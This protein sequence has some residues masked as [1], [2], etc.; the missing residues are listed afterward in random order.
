MKR[1]RASDPKLLTCLTSNPKLPQS[2]IAGQN[3]ASAR[4]TIIFQ[5]CVLIL[6]DISRGL[7]QHDAKKNN[8]LLLIIFFKNVALV[9]ATW[10]SRS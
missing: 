3:K 1:S 10:F 7:S 9:D 4:K 6:V 2:Y 8:M 5:W